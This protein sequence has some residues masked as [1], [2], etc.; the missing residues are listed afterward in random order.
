MDENPLNFARIVPEWINQ[1]F[2]D[3]VIQHM[4]KDPQAKALE[5]DIVPGSTPGDNFGSAIYRASIKFSSKFT[6]S[7][8]KTI[9]IIIKAQ[10]PAEIPWE[11]SDFL[12]DSPLF[13]TE[14]GMYGE[15]L[16][17]IKSLWLAVGDKEL[18]CPE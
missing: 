14:M 18:L 16:P 7:G 9:F 10:M 11:F 5:F 6:K 1:S 15:V 8:P 3:R 17:E 4:E 13:Q 12:R 2:F